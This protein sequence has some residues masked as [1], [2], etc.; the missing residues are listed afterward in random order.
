MSKPHLDRENRQTHEGRIFAL[1]LF[2]GF[3]VVAAV[4]YLRGHEV[5]G[6]IAAS[7][8]AAA[9][10]AGVVIPGH[11]ESPR[12][13]WMKLGEIIGRVTNPV[14]LAIIYYGVVTPT[15]LLRRGVGLLRKRRN[16]PGWHRRPPLSPPARMERQF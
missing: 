10:I 12:R 2:A 1:T 13:A 3:V 16:V 4:A 8:A 6:V 11:L 9:L 15:G 5:S 14:I 7:I